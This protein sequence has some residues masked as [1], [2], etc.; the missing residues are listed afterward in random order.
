MCGPFTAWHRD[1][2]PHFINWSPDG[3]HLIFDD[4][5]SVRLVDVNGTRLRQIVDANPGYRFREGIGPYAQFSPD[6]QAIVY[7]SCEFSTEGDTL[8]GDAPRD[9]RGDYQF[10]IATVGVDGTGGQRRTTDSY[11]DHLP[12][13]SPDGRRIAY[14]SAGHPF[15]E[16]SLDELYVVSVGAADV[17][18]VALVRDLY[19]A[20][21]PQWAPDGTQLAVLGLGDD[22]QLGDWVAKEMG[23]VIAALDGSTPRTVAHTVSTVSWSPDGQRLALARL[24]GNAVQL[25]TIAPDGS[26]AQVIRRLTDRVGLSAHVDV[27]HSIYNVPLLH[28]AWAPDGSHFLYSCGQQFCVVDL[29][30]EIVGRT[31]EEVRQRAGTSTSRGGLGAGRV[32]DR[33]AD[34]GRPDAR[35]RGGAVHDGAGRLRRAGAGARGWRWRTRARGTWGR[36]R[37]RAVRGDVVPAPNC[38]PG[39]VGNCETLQALR[40]RLAGPTPL[41]W[42][43]G[44][45]L[46]PWA[47]IQVS[48][49]PSRVTG[50]KFRLWQGVHRHESLRLI[51]HLPPAIGDLDQ[52]QTLDLSGHRFFN[53]VPREL[54]GLAHLRELDLRLYGGAW[55]AGCLSAAFVEQL[56]EAHGVLRICGQESSQ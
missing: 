38:N 10:E 28:V 22:V 9:P 54:E 14:L 53:E 16:R 3:T 13:W 34:V 51:G 2:P 21:P 7:A 45:P 40:D 30:G 39:L 17:D 6:G 43:A 5:T 55:I 44:T 11:Y 15:K 52:L 48:G 20:A 49:E 35:R 18:P 4:V 24:H 56:D 8:R 29:D 47:G 33:G 25:V 23:V 12:V 42:G 26:D 36:G 32:A 41:N 27:Q 1:P 19:V 50:L 37:T 46:A 31:P